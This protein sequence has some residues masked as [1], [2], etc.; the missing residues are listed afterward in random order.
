MTPMTDED[1]HEFLRPLAGEPDGPQRLD[2]AEI[3]RVGGRRRRRRRLATG[4]LTTLAVAVGCGAF[5][6][7]Q[8]HSQPGPQPRVT[9][10]RRRPPP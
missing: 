10:R 4:G 8:P 9:G 6:A 2:L 3:E 1:A 7:V 5:F